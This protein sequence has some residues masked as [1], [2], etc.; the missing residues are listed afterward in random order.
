MDF[1][2]LLTSITIFFFFFQ[3]K[4]LNIYDDII[5]GYKLELY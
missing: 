5:N 2:E 3:M 1:L 4:I